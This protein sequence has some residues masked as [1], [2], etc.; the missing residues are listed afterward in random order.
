MVCSLRHFVKR[1][2]S[3]TI[4]GAKHTSKSVKRLTPCPVSGL[5]TRDRLQRYSPLRN[6]KWRERAMYESGAC[7]ESRLVPHDI[8]G[9]A[10]TKTQTPMRPSC[11]D[12]PNG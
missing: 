3:H 4:Y 5:P 12:S 8:W 2:S 6:G 1:W 10:G 7:V 11:Q 9:L